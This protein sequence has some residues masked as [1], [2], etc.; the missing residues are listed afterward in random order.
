ME[1]VKSR[2]I[3]LYDEHTRIEG[4]EL[5][6]RMKKSFAHAKNLFKAIEPWV[7]SHLSGGVKPII[8]RFFSTDGFY[9]VNKPEESSSVQI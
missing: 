8:K 1:P 7:V 6:L 4:A 5:S 2:K 9:K 3:Q